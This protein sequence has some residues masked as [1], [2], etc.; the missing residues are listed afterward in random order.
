MKLNGGPLN[1]GNFAVKNRFKNAGIQSWITLAIGSS[2]TQ[3]GF[4]KIKNAGKN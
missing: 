3:V 2:K 1:M 4:N